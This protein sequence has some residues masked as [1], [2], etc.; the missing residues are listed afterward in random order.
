M[1]SEFPQIADS[2]ENIIVLTPN[3]HFY[4]AHPNNKTSVIDKKYQTIC[5]ISKLDSIEINNRAG[6]IDYSLEEFVNVLNV[7][8]E[9]DFFNIGMDYEEI[10]HQIMNHVYANA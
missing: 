9:T 2:P 6:Q 7:G 3:Q 10:K 8:F 5:L 1:E 4:R